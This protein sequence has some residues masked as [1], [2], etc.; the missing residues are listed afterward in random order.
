MSKFTAVKL[1][2]GRFDHLCDQFEKEISPD[3]LRAFCEAFQDLDN[4]WLEAYQ[5]RR[6]DSR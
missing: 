3:I 6:R 1:A 5:M 4:A 2:R